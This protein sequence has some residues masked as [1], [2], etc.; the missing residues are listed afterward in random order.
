[1]GDSNNS[2][3]DYRIELSGWGLDNA[4]FTERTELMWTGDGDKQVQLHRALAEGSI[5]FIRLLSAEPSSGSVPVAYHVDEIVLMDR[6]GRY[7]IKLGQPHPRSK[8]SQT[9]NRASNWVEEEQSP[10]DINE[11]GMEL[12]AVEVL[13]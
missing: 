12:E 8:Q 4:F 9:A 2:R 3:G 13:R 5:A 6:N 7:Q 10:C 11:T 1:M